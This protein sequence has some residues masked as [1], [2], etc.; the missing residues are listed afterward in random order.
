M[1]L[2]SIA[3]R[4]SVASA[5]DFLS[6]RDMKEGA[7]DSVAATLFV[8]LRASDRQ[9]TSDYVYS[10]SIAVVSGRSQLGK[11]LDRRIVVRL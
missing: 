10:D 6:C 4:G 8:R 9:I 1:P 5:V 3:L 11:R 2:H 7:A